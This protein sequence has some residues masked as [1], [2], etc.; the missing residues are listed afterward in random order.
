MKMSE[1]AEVAPRDDEMT[2]HAHIR[3]QIAGGLAVLVRDLEPKD[4]G[5]LR[6][7]RLPVQKQFSFSRIT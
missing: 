5:L 3:F 6:L 1:N 2:G 7:E 4:H